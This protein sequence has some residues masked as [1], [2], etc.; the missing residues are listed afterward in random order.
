MF[1]NE[2]F[3]RGD[4]FDFWPDTYSIAPV[5]KT[6]NDFKDVSRKWGQQL[7]D[8]RHV[9]CNLRRREIRV[10]PVAMLSVGSRP[11]RLAKTLRP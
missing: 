8:L 11:F 1:F 4:L 9:T 5:R 7:Q 6:A 10:L 3:F 2:C